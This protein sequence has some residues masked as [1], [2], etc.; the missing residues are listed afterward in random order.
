NDDADK[1]LEQQFATWQ[2]ATSLAEKLRTM[3]KAKAQDGEAFGI[4]TNN[5]I[6]STPVQLDVRL[7]EADQVATP[8]LAWPTATPVDG[9]VFDGSG[10]PRVYN[11]LKSHPGDFFLTGL[12]LAYDPY[13]AESVL[14]WFRADRPGQHRGIPELMPALGLFA[15]LRRW[16]LATLTAAETAA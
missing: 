5:P 11:V 2:K 13:P 1:F 6:L 9:I 8:D 12:N 14:H 15:Q 16:T 7:V 3:R 4:L 10:N